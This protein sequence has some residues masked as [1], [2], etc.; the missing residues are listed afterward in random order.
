MR[1]ILLL[2]L[3]GMLSLLVACTVSQNNYDDEDDDPDNITYNITNRNITNNNI[4]GNTTIVNRTVINTTTI[5]TNTPSDSNRTNSVSTTTLL[6]ANISNVTTRNIA[7]PLGFLARPN[8]TR[9]YPGVVMIHEW[10]GLNDNIKEM[11]KILASEGYSVFAIDLYGEVT[12][13][14]SRAQNLSSQVRANQDEA[15]AKMQ[16]AVEFLREEE[17]ATNIGSVGWCFGGGESLVLSVNEPLDATVIYYGTL[18][19]DTRQLERI[20]GPVLGIFGTNDTSIP[21][22]SVTAFNKTLDD[23][24][25]ERDIYLYPGVGHAF[26]NPSG[27]NFAPTQT[28]DAWFKTLRFL[29]ENLK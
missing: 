9:P 4:A 27:A 15:L 18:I 8:D 23:A 29:E 26:A 11:A 17:D 6:G 7:S 12:N 14:M 25:I 10:W 1:K 20:G 28:R 22:A 5:I 2:F 3:I 24:G 21:A 16:D 19:N 13:N